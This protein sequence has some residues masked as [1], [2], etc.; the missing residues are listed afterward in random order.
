MSLLEEIKQRYTQEVAG[1]D[2]DEYRKE[3]REEAYEYGV[4]YT[5]FSRPMYGT[6]SGISKK[7]L[8]IIS[9]SVVALSIIGIILYKRKKKKK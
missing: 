8:W 2:P 9:G 7:R 6:G 1:Y 3:I 4:K 5:D